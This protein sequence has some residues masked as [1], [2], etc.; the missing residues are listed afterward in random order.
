[1]AGE[2][3]VVV[4][5]E[6]EVREVRKQ[7]IPRMYVTAVES[8]DGSYRMEFDTHEELVLYREGERLRVTVARSVPE[9]R[10]GEDY[11]V[12]ATLVS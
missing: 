2:G 8:S 11:V 6:G 7:L 3:D 10:E 1:M 4:S 5:F 9:Y 12:H